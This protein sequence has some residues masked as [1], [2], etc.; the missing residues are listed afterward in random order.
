MHE[1]NWIRMAGDPILRRNLELRSKILAG[2]RDFFSAEG[3]L[4]VDPPA[5]VPLAGMEPHLDP[6]EVRLT[7]QKG[8]SRPFHLHT[9]PEYA[10][11]KLLSAGLERIYS[12]SHAFRN[13]EISDHHNPE[14]M[15]LE[16]YRAGEDYTKLIEDCE[17]LVSHLLK[18]LGSGWKL[19]YGDL[20][21]DLRP[22]WPRLGIREI[23]LSHAGVDLEKITDTKRLAAAARKLGLEE[24]DGS[25]QWDDIFFLIFLKEVEPAL[26]RERPCFLVD[27]PV[28][29]ASL[30]RRKPQA[31][32]W[33]ERFELYAGGLELANAF[34]ELT[35][36]VEQRQRLFAERSHRERMGKTL[37]PMDESF[38]EALER[39]LPDCAGIALGV[40]RLVMLLAGASSIREVIPFPAGDLI[41][42]W[43]RAHS[44]QTQS[45]RDHSPDQ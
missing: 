40:D 5:L 35:D 28:E 3:F 15:L 20:E 44:L 1:P 4:E 38:L 7:D 43:E 34:S 23:F 6:M 9:S 45:A 2:I 17:R 8:R 32:R 31:P 22:P 41:A 24:V 26:P 16:W 14:F 30:A 10:M 21:I 37:Y 18:R 12:L 29:M 36:P 42:D 13:G 27:Y 39:G 33:A 19:R 11:K 25:W